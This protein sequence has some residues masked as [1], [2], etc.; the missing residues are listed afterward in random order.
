MTFSPY[1]GRPG[2][3]PYSFCLV[4]NVPFS[5]Y[6]GRPGLKLGVRSFH[7][8]RLFF[9]LHSNRRR[10]WDALRSLYSDHACD[11]CGFVL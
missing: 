1:P 8:P 6:P 2:L 7:W 9:I 11:E 4:F 10:A 5:P 3:K